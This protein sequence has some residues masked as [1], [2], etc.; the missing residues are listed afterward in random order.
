MVTFKARRILILFRLFFK[1]F[2]QNFFFKWIWSIYKFFGVKIQTEVAFWAP[3]TQA[4]DWL[5]GNIIGVE[6]TTFAVFSGSGS[7]WG[8][9]PGPDWSY[10]SQDLQT[11]I[12]CWSLFVLLHPHSLLLPSSTPPPPSSLETCLWLFFYVQFWVSLSRYIHK[13]PSWRLYLVSI[14]CV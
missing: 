3:C 10:F 11:F 5:W 12:T 8:W 14:Q 6:G 1:V 7:I 13:M 2:N 4:A 9:F